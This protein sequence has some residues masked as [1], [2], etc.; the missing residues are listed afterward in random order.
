MDSFLLRAPI[1]TRRTEFF[2]K[3]N[4][5]VITV[6]RKVEIRNESI[7]QANFEVFF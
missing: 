7:I 6:K 3:Q 4:E 5:V 2:I 1:E